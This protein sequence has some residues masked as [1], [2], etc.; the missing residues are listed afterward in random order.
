MTRPDL[1][2]A[3][4]EDIVGND[5]LKRVLKIVVSAA[6]KEERAIPHTILHG[7]YGCGKC[8]ARGTYVLLYNGEL[9]LVEDILTGDELMGP[10]SLPRKVLSTCHGFDEMYEVV[11]KKGKSYIV[12]KPHILSL[13]EVGTENIVNISVKDYL[14]KSVY[15]KS[16]HT[17][18]KVGVNFK[19][20]EVPID[21][22]FIGLWLGD[23]NSAN[24]GITVSNNAT[25]CYLIKLAKEFGYGVRVSTK[26]NSRCYTLSIFS[27]NR[28]NKIL[29]IL[30]KLNLIKNKHIPDIFKINSRKIRLQLLAGLIDSD[31]YLYGDNCYEIVTKYSALM[32]DIL[33]LCRSLG[34]SVYYGVKYNKKYK[35]NYYRIIIS[36]NT[37]EIPV[38]IKYKKANKR[39]QSKNVLKVGIKEVLPKGFGEYYGFELSGD[40]LFLLGDFTVTHNTSI[41]RVLATEIGGAFIEVNAA[42]IKSKE[43]LLQ[44]IPKLENQCVLFIDEIH[45]LK[46]KHEELFYSLMEDFKAFIPHA[47]HIE[48]IK[49]PQF[50]LV[51]ATTDLGSLSGPFLSRFIQNHSVHMYSD[52]DLAKIVR[53]NAAKLKIGINDNAAVLIAKRSKNVPRYAN[54]RLTWV[55]DYCSSEDKVYITEKEVNEALDL[56]GIDEQGFDETDRKYLDAVEKF[57][58]I[59]L[60]NLAAAIGATPETVVKYIEP[61]MLA[62]DIITISREGRTLKSYTKLSDLELQYDAPN[63]YEYDHPNVLGDLS[64]LLN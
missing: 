42:A 33:Y 18:Y 31:G 48:E 57:Q 19:E 64:D 63:S 37:E 38:K 23:G 44:L 52:E 20:K 54:N 22:Y 7:H 36:G 51:G 14:S 50:T 29:K 49:I 55:K 8:L 11:P 27:K 4:F 39:R 6:K 46:T 34:L 13:K 61:I 43:D 12:N 3:K 17:G 56:I 47:G 15:F 45:R 41:A 62:R 25:L 53:L 2:P 30:Q 1:R 58:P 35:K 32:N 28:K 60:T 26:T 5:N 10:D 21:P 59:G 16:Q 9:K 24:Q 40:G